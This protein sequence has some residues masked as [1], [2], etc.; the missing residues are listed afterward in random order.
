MLRTDDFEEAAKKFRS[1]YSSLQHLTVDI[2]GVN[3]VFKGEYIK[4]SESIKFTTIV[5]DIGDKTP[6]LENLKIALVLETEMLDW[7]IRVQVYEKQRDDKDRGPI[8]D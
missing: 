1:C 6:E 7:V 8:I 4:P 3:A 2:N 5:F